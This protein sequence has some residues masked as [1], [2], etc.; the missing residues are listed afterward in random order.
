L[1]S[2]EHPIIKS[3][4]N[5]F[6]QDIVI[7]K[8]DF[9]SKQMM[10]FFTDTGG[11]FFESSNEEILLQ[12]PTK[13]EL[14]KVWNKT[15][16]TADVHKKKIRLDLEHDLDRKLDGTL[17]EIEESVTKIEVEETS[18]KQPGLINNFFKD[19]RSQ[20]KQRHLQRLTR[21]T[22]MGFRKLKNQKFLFGGGVL[23]A[24]ISGVVST[25][26]GPRPVM[27]IAFSLLIISALLWIVAPAEFSMFHVG[28]IFLLNGAAGMG[29]P[30]ALTHYFLNAVSEKDRIS[31][32]LFISMI[33]GT[34]AGLFSFVIGSG[35][36]KF[37]PMFNYSGL[38]VFKIYFGIIIFLLVGFFI[39]LTTLEKLKD[40][41]P[42]LTD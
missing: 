26:S 1:K 18:E 4:V 32:S 5:Q 16:K 19:Y 7:E 33:S 20:Q 3:I 11:K 31:Y 38:T 24:S 42:K 37:I 21:N 22:R 28:L 13:K 40:W 6:N 10:T 23:I 14:I 35:L 36:L 15:N 29:T 39:L 30:M 12:P 17:G 8:V 41:V 34:I 2:L 27:L 9:I 25:Y